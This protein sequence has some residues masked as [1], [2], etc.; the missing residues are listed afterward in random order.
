[1]NELRI[2]AAGER[3]TIGQHGF[4]QSLQAPERAGAAE[5]RLGQ[6]RCLAECGERIVVAPGLMEQV[7]EAEPRFGQ[8]RRERHRPLETSHRGRRLALLEQ[9]GSEIGM[10]L[11]VLG[12]ERDRAPVTGRGFVHPA[13]LLEH[14]SETIVRLRKARIHGQRA[15]AV[16]GRIIE[17]V[18]LAQNIAEIE[19]GVGIIGP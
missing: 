12:L 10:G 19:M 7:T 6:I 13:L 3:P 1:M 14:I 8:A 9:R 5:P 4:R 17:P 15:P 18:L 2:G 11:G 16:S